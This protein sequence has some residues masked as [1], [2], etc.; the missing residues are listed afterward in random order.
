VARGEPL[1]RQWN[2]L[3]ILQSYHYGVGVEE[4]AERLHY[5]VR[6][7]KRDLS[8][9]QQ[10]GFP[11]SFEQR[12]RGKRAWKLA[13][14]FLERGEL[15]LSVTEMVSLYLSRQLLAPLVGTQFGDGVAKAI[16][17]IKA[18]LPKNALGHFDSLDEALLVKIMPRHDYSRQDKEIRI[19]NQAIAENRTLRIQYESAHTGNVY[20]WMCDPL[21]IALF[22]VGL[23]CVA[24]I[25]EVA[26]VRPL[27]VDRIREISLTDQ[28][29]MR[30]AD[31]S[32]QDYLNNSFGIFAPGKDGPVSVEVRFDNWAATSVRELQWHP[33]QKILSDDGS[34]LLASF[35]LPNATEFKRW[36]LG[37]GRHAVVL[38]PKSLADEIVA[39][40]DAARAAYR[41]ES[42]P[43]SYAVPPALG[44]PEPLV[45]GESPAAWLKTRAQVQRQRRKSASRRSPS[46][47]LS[48]R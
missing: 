20:D 23:Y 17:K 1:I 44:Q 27:K 32:L 25:E 41:A 37:F 33:S 48:R 6:T 36:L 39:E 5:T 2:L 11:I 22:G 7:V 31:F 16:E 19:I 46:P 4:L 29:F 42:A 9:L 43:A 45:V 15:I 13:P 12:D 21:G 35:E 3:K 38:K 24:R 8:V 18:L 26:E 28:F 47:S 14:H 40:M 10:A 30:P 34:S